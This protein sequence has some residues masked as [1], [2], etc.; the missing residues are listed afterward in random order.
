MRTRL[1]PIIAKVNEFSHE[2]QM[3]MDTLEARSEAESE[4]M[5]LICLIKDSL[6]KLDAVLARIDAGVMGDDS[7]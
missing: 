6:R 5:R 7:D 1:T 2:Y 4:A 3:E